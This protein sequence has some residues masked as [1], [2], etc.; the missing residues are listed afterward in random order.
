MWIIG[1]VALLVVVA[2][3]GTALGQVWGPLLLAV[4]AA[5]WGVLLLLSG[6]GTFVMIG[7]GYLLVGV[8]EFAAARE[9]WTS[10][11][12]PSRSWRVG[13]A[14]TGVAGGLGTVLLLLVIAGMI[15]S[16][17]II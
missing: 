8:L 11:E 16:A 14:L 10:E 5:G 3:I 9:F 12:G 17:M 6:L 15:V 4:G 13:A 1:V 2:I 7:V